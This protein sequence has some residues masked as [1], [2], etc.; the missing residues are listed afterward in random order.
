MWCNFRWVKGVRRGDIDRRSQRDGGRKG[1]REG[2]EGERGGG[3]E[4]GLGW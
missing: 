3:R 1:R 4:E 2:R